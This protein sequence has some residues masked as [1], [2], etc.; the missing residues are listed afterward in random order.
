MQTVNTTVAAGIMDR[1]L[2][3]R[4]KSHSGPMVGGRSRRRQDGRRLCQ[5]HHLRFLVP[6]ASA[7]MTSSRHIA[8]AVMLYSSRH[9]SSSLSIVFFGVVR[10]FSCVP[11]RHP[12][13]G[14]R[15]QEHAREPEEALPFLFTDSN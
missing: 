11:L 5:E 4:V 15:E 10:F 12:L 2:H 14:P 7:S 6:P 13:A 1:S 3:Q 9:E 8:S